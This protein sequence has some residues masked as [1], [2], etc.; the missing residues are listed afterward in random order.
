[1]KGL[2][3]EF[4]PIVGKAAAKESKGGAAQDFIDAVK[5]GD[6]ATVKSAFKLMLEECGYATKDED[7]D[8]DED[9]EE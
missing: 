6:A 8:K 3:K 2:E 5:S 9:D 4:G 7:K 1:M